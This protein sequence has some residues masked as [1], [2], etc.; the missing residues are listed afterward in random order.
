MMQDQ[1]LRA[2]Q[3][4]CDTVPNEEALTEIERRRGFYRTRSI[5]SGDLLEVE[6]YP[7][8]PKTVIREAMQKHPASREA[9]KRLNQRNAEK[10]LLR[11]METNFGQGDWYFTATLEG[12]NLPTVEGMQRMIRRFIS[13]LNY[14]RKT[15]GM[16]NARYI[17]VIEGYEEGSKQKRLHVHFIIDGGL[18]RATLKEIWGHGRC[19]C[20]ELDPASYGGLVNL[21]KYMSKDPRG[22]KRWSASKGLKGPIVITAERKVNHKTA[23][24]IAESPAGAAAALEKL[25]PGY[26]HVETEVRTNPF[27][28]GCYI[29]AVMRRKEGVRKNEQGRTGGKIGNRAGT[30]AGGSGSDAALRVSNGSAPPVQKRKGRV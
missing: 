5:K 2:W 26:E 1:T 16:D 29:Y 17:Y 14:R 12:A 22:R 7:I 23:R 20:D 3:L 30:H 4:L 27:I 25:Y 21:A 8:L 10:R 15:A 11:L 19:K 24:R 28:A 6:A 9:Q 13:R 18:D